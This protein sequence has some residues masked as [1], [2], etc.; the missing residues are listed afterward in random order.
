MVG[1][2]RRPGED[3][4]EAAWRMSGGRCAEE[5]QFL[6]RG[7]KGKLFPS[8]TVIALRPLFKFLLL[9]F[10][11]FHLFLLPSPP[12]SHPIQS[13]Q[14]Q[15]GTTANSPQEKRWRFLIGSRGAL[16]SASAPKELLLISMP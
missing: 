14:P 5:A 3:R 11:K 1:A 6:R 10:P 4:G 15:T 12:P 2:G 7:L 8:Q 13:D 9:P 16:G